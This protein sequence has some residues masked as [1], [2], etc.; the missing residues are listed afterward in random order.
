[1]NFMPFVRIKLQSSLTHVQQKQ[2]P[3]HAQLKYIYVLAFY[4]IHRAE[5]WICFLKGSSK[6]FIFA[7]QKF[8]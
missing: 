8:H 7:H 1:L 6:V 2:L 4:V 5:V 3:Q